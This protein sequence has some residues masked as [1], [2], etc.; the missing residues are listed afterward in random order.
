MGHEFIEFKNTS[1]ASL[2]YRKA[3]GKILNELRTKIERYI[4]SFQK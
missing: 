2:A 4:F 3:L 1:A